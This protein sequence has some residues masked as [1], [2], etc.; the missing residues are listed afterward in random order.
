[1][2][3]TSNYRS[4]Y[5]LAGTEGPGVAVPITSDAEGGVSANDVTLDAQGALGKAPLD[6][7]TWS[8]WRA[9]T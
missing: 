2:I 8:A 3:V 5:C 1:M 6:S 7:A 4:A 9:R